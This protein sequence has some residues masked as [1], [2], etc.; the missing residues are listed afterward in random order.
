MVTRQI[1]E[2]GG[3]FG[4]TPWAFVSVVVFLRNLGQRDIVFHPAHRTSA[5]PAAARPI[6]GYTAKDPGT[7]VPKILSRRRSYLEIIYSAKRR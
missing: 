2:G 5:P 3:N 7:H 4:Q 1:G 6:S